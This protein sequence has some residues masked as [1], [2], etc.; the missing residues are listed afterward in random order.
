[1]RHACSLQGGDGLR[2]EMLARALGRQEEDLVQP[3]ARTGLEQRKDRRDRLADARRR[4]GHQTPAQSSGLEH[5]LRQLALPRAIAGIR[6]TEVGQGVVAA[7]AVIEL[8]RAPREKG[9]AQEFEK[10]AQLLRAALLDE[11]GFFLPRDLEVDERDLELAQTQLRA[12]EGAIH[13]RL[14]PMQ[15]P[16]V[17]RHPVKVAPIGLHFL[18]Q[19]GGGVESIGAA[20]NSQ[21][22]EL[23]HQGHFVLASNAAPRGDDAVTGD[24]LLRRRR[25][26]KAM[27]EIATLRR[28]L[29]ELA[30]G[31]GVGVGAGVRLLAGLGGYGQQC[32][33]GNR[34][35]GRSTISFAGLNRILFMH[36]V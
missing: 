12:E 6:E 24:P 17:R 5:V 26:R 3:L 21:G 25:R 34:E 7:L 22:L 27:V 8:L 20:A 36:P 10:R 14:R 15:G 29:A 31:D 11:R 19:A 18:E 2:G 9:L 13:L 33:T 1:M 32:A 4:L 30:H 35:S 23:A 28:E 16:V